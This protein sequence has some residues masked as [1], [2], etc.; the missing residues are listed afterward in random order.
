MADSAVAGPATL[1]TVESSA[2]SLSGATPPRI[3]QKLEEA[4]MFDAKLNELPEEIMDSLSLVHQNFF[5]GEYIQKEKIKSR[6]CI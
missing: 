5:N 3:R 2:D 4:Q 1:T 6:Q